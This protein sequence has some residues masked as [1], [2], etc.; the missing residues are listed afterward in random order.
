MIKSQNPFS[1]A[2][3]YDAKLRM[4]LGGISGS[5]KT[6]TALTFAQQICDM[7][8]EDAA[9]AFVDTEGKSSEKYADI[10]K[11]HSMYMDDD[12]HPDKYVDAINAAVKYGY[13]VIV[14]DSLSHAWNGN[15]GILQI[16]GGNWKNWKTVAPIE[17]KLWRTILTANIHIIATIRAREKVVAESD[18]RGRVKPVNIGME[19]VQR[20]DSK[21]E[22]DI[23]G[24][25]DRNNIMTIEKTRYRPWRGFTESSPTGDTIAPVIEWLKGEPPPPPPKTKADLVEYGNELGISSYEIRDILQQNNADFDPA[26]WDEITTWIDAYIAVK[27]NATEEKEEQQEVAPLQE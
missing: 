10:F 4:A 7:I 6:Y 15:N 13:P 25:M 16:V 20:K 26:R 27:Q 5:G 12:H 14:I 1:L 11:F 3:R 17:Q 9:P 23:V 18:D 21:F 19:L 22:F 24:M 2:V 8:G